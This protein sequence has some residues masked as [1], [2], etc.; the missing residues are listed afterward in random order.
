MPFG[1][2]LSVHPVTAHAVG[3][4]AGQ[5]LETAGE[6]PDLAVLFVTPG[7]AGALEDAANVVRR[8]LAPGLLIGC[9][10]VSVVGTGQE[11][12]DTAGVSLWA[13]HVGPVSPLELDVRPSSA[14]PVVSGLD[15][16]APGSA[17][18]ALLLGDPFS[19]PA[20]VAFDAF[21]HYQP[22]L[23][24]VGGMASAGRG[25][26]GNRLVV[27]DRIR[28]S[29]A[30]GALLHGDGVA[31]RS[32]VS[33]GCRP[34]GRPMTV[35]RAEGT[36]VYELAGAPAFQRLVELAQNS[37]GP[38]EVTLINQG[39]LHLGLVIDEHRVEFG[40]G[41][42][43]VRNVL[44][45][46]QD[47][48][49][50]QVGAEVPLGSTVQFHLRDAAAADLDLHA[51]LAGAAAD[52]ALLFTCNGR[53]RRLFGTPDHDAAALAEALGPVPTSGLFC[54][55]EFGPVGGQNFVHGFTASMAL[56]SQG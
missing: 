17:R 1:A 49:A 15:G 54:A 52:A 12:E 27:N 29:G 5:V 11:V 41:D 42:F 34:V 36:I 44:G 30:V 35:T 18:A 39:G 43:L 40:P 48:G 2:A 31:V 38:E 20:E 28:T 6:A 8:V 37:L 9:A 19:F 33:Q 47:N 14:G 22:G 26:G 13:G 16:D 25:P 53:G 55:G 21:R 46:D 3:E 23:V 45:A 56:F 7:H 24:V 51:V 4:V 10:A 32:L 50:I